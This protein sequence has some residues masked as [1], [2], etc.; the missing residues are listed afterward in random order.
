MKITKIIEAIEKNP[1]IIIHR[2]VRPDPDAIGSQGGLKALI[3]H[4]FPEKEVYAVGEDVLSLAFLA[5]MDQVPDDAYRESLVIVCDTA[6]Q[7]RIDDERYRTG[8]QLIKID[9]HPITDSYGD[10]EWVSTESSSTSEMIVE[11]AMEAKSRG[12]ALNKEAARLLYAGIVGDTGRFKFPSTTV[13]TFQY[14]G[15]L[16]RYDFD[17]TALYDA[18]Y[19]AEEKVLRLN[20]HILQHFQLSENGLCV[21]KLSAELLK[22]FNVTVEETNQLV[23]VV[24]DVKGI[25]VW[26]FLIEEAD[27]IRVRIRSKGA[28]I[29]QIARKYNGGGHPLA[30]GATVYTWDEAKDLE[31]DL[32]K[33]CKEYVEGS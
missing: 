5:K 17:R 22:E 27:Q 12:W 13:K 8:N 26:M 16:V 1:K 18:L 10:I 28:V 32:E 4:S 7:P 19:Q 2:H 14:A 20:G 31:A 3:K 25:K 24:A 11:L 21:I 33:V 9:H 15:E 30:S 29:N 23:Q 6:N